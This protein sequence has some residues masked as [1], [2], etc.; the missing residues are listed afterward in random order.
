MNF[1]KIV[2]TGIT[3]VF[4]FGCASDQPAPGQIRPDISK[5]PVAESE[6][7]IK[8]NLT[9]DM[10]AFEKQ[11]IEIAKKSEVKYN[12][13]ME[14]LKNVKKK[15]ILPATRIPKN[16]GKRLTFCYDGYALML[17]K[18]VA[19]EAGYTFNIGKLVMQDSPIIHRCYKN[20]TVADILQDVSGDVGYDVVINENKMTVSVRYAE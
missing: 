11:L 10:K 6:V 5:A 15:H 7:S 12:Q 16:M 18:R 2:F 14:L 3:V 4:F 17:V 8:V 9:S 13:Y 19:E 20:T 1:K